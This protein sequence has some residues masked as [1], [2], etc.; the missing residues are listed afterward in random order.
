ML[1]NAQNIFV[2]SMSPVWVKLG[3][4]GASKRILAQATTTLYTQVLTQGYSA[5]E[6]L[7]LDSN[8]ETSSYTNSVD[9]WSLG[10]VI[11]ELLVGTKLFVSEAQV[12]RYFYRKRPFSEDKLKALST[13][14]DDLGISLLKS[15]LLIQPEDRPTAEGALGHGWL[16]GL[17]TGNEDSAGDKDETTQSRGQSTVSRKRK[18]G[19]ATHDR[20]KKR[21]SG[22]NPTRQD[23]AR[24]IPVDV[25]LEVNAGS[26][27]FGDLTPKVI[28]N[29]RVTTPLDADFV[30]GSVVQAGCRKPEFIPHNSQA[31]HSN[32]SKAPRKKNIS[33]ISQTRPESSTPNT[34]PNSLIQYM[35]AGV[36]CR[37]LD[38]LQAIHRRQTFMVEIISHPPRRKMGEMEHT[39][40]KTRKVRNSTPDETASGITIGEPTLPRRAG[41]RKKVPKT[42]SMK[43][44]T[45]STRCGTS[46]KHAPNMNSMRRPRTTRNPNTGQNPNSGQTLIAS[47]NPS[48]NANVGLGRGRNQGRNTNLG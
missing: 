27:C 20:Q 3:D 33:N 30:E 29:T 17:K 9:I 24:C 34:K 22:K 43:P 16:T 7:G 5:P 35:L 31:T 46:Q 44:N 11:Y 4:F 45:H 36:G 48:W 26:H 23:D 13:L 1:T 40:K 2:V 6:V 42:Q 38:H 28:A 39:Q 15:M 12:Y 8:S 37:I 19:R 10:C 21:R 47:R 25:T 32:G 41:L 14:T 18:T